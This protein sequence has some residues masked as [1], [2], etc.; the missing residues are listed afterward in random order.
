MK[1]ALMK[2]ALKIAAIGVGVVALVVGLVALGGLIVWALWNALVP[3]LVNGPSITF[4]QGVL[5]NVALGVVG[6]VF[7]RR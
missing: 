7:G 6:A 4:V 2:N 1:N 5:I 3:P